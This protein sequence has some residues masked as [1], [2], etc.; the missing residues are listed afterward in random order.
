[1]EKQLE[2][3]QQE[4]SEDIK[5]SL[6][7]LQQQ[8][9]QNPITYQKWV[10]YFSQVKFQLKLAEN[11]KS[12]VL[13]NRLDFLTGRGDEPCITVYEKSEFKIVLAAD[14]ELQKADSKV[15]VLNLKLEFIREALEAIKQRG[16]ALK[17][18]LDCN[19]FEQGDF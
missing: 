19:K 3:L 9:A 8:I 17:N 13:K 11:Q 12:V 14:P 6:I 1:M 18:I 7:N 10:N 2:Q 15:F 5:I 16:F 4:L